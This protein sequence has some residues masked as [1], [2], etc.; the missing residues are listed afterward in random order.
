MAIKRPKPEKIVAKLR[1]VEVLMG[2]GMHPTTT[3]PSNK[4]IPFKGQPAQFGLGR[5]E[6]LIS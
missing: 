3:T 2:Q 6:W 4:H 5:H 1:Q